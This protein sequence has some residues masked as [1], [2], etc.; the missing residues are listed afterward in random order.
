[1][2]N[3]KLLEEAIQQSGLKKSFIAQ[4]L[5]MSRPTFNAYLKGKAEFRV[6]HMNILCDLLRINPEQRETIFFGQDG[7]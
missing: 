3:K 4:Q 2:T 6:T 1:M 5:G 7:A